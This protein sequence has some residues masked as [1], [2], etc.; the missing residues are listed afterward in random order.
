M[1]EKISSYLWTGKLK[2]ARN[3]L[4][5]EWILM[6]IDNIKVEIKKCKN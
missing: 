6:Q 5:K 2:K 4:H 1:E 3:P